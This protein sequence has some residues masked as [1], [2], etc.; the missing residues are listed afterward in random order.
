YDTATGGTVQA[1][2]KNL[3]QFY[4][5]AIY[6]SGDHGSQ[7]FR[8]PERMPHAL[9]SEKAAQDPG[10]W[11]DDDRITAEGS[12]QRLRPFP[13]TFQGP[14]GGNRDRGHNKA[15]TDDAQGVLSDGNGLGVSGEQPDELRGKGQA[16]YGAGGH[17]AGTKCGRQFVNFLYAPVFPGAVIVADQRAHA[18]HN[19]AAGKIEESLQLIV[20]AQHNYI[21]LGIR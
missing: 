20:D 6:H 14:G 16:D 13:K 7:H 2:S 8:D 9:R 21:T 5:F 18:L 3:R 17:D 12:D 1:V 19:P 15:K 10:Q 11:H 4:T